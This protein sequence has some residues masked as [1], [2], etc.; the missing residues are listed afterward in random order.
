LARLEG[1]VALITGAS[2]GMGECEA[3]IFAAEGAAVTLADVL[4]EEGE[5]VAEAIRADGGSA[6]FVALDVTDPAAWADAVAATESAFG[7]LNVLVN[8]AGIL[9]GT[10]L[11]DTDLETWQRVVDVNQTGVFLGLQH[12]VP[13][14]R[15]AGGGSIVNIASIAALIGLPNAAAYQATK[16]AVRALSRSA[17]VELAPYG[18]RVNSVYPGR[19]ETPMTESNKD[20]QDLILS[21]SLL[22]RTAKPEEVAWGVLYLA[23]DE[24]SFVTGAELV[25]DGGFTA[26]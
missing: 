1:K 19:I 13:A 7:R 2:R 24:A 21:R 17:A 15:R 5:Q 20:R 9:R 11:L 25:I 22:G 14:L 16:G 10:S 12:A 3:R 4:V 18:I 6:Q 23:S 8:N 26:S